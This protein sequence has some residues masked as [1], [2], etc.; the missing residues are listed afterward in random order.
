[1]IINN[2]DEATVVCGLNLKQMTQK[3]D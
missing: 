3:V 1:M 2:N